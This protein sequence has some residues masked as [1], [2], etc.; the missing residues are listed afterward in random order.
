MHSLLRQPPV[1]VISI[2]IDAP[3]ASCTPLQMDL[4]AYFVTTA[5]LLCQCCY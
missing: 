4:Q 3:A 5:A 2:I 1:H